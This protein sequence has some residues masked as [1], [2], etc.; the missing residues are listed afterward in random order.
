MLSWN[1]TFDGQ[2]PELQA[3]IIKDL[4]VKPSLRK[5]LLG[6]LSSDYANFK[7]RHEEDV[8]TP[9]VNHFEAGFA[10]IYHHI[11]ET[12]EADDATL[13]DEPLIFKARKCV[14]ELLVKKI[15]GEIN[16]YG[17]YE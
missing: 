13:R 12:V 7:I 17:I 6:A 14:E 9:M 15:S 3:E 11:M 1:K 5:V 8:I 2:F 16:N 10:K 4:Y